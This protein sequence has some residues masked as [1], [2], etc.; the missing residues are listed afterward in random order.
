MTAGT[1]LVGMN[2][3]NSREDRK[4]HFFIQEPTQTTLF[5]LRKTFE[6][7]SESSNPLPF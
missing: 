2:K 3:M 6:I 7:P 5:D 4:K 1:G